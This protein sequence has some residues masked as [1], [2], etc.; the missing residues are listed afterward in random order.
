MDAVPVYSYWFLSCML[1]SLVPEVLVSLPFKIN[2][3]ETEN[4]YFETQT[5]KNSATV[6]TSLLPVYALV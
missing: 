6:T 4:S 1:Q 5:Q 3:R 2:P